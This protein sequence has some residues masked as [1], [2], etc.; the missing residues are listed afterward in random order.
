MTW[1]TVIL[2]TGYVPSRITADMKCQKAK[3]EIISLPAGKFSIR[4]NGRSRR[5]S[6]PCDIFMRS[7]VVLPTWMRQVHAAL[8]SM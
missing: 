5:V 3:G 7:G 6:G 1:E 4:I 2:D 8:P